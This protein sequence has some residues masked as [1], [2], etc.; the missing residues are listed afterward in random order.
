MTE[1]IEPSDQIAQWV[2]QLAADDPVVREKS[3]KQL[4]QLGGHDVT[5]ALVQALIDPRM[6]IRWEAAKALHVIA[7][8]VTATALM[9]AL[10]D[11]DEK[12]RWAAAQGLIALKQVGL[13][14]VLSGLLKRA[15]S[16]EFCKAAHHVL[17]AQKSCAD[18][19]APSSTHWKNRN[20][21]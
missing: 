3:R 1:R 17:H 12:V 8:P 21:G 10:D 14:A 11:D 6:H 9:H 15:G 13:L 5:R 4:V 19:V 7:D 2:N 16:M 18:V 20:R